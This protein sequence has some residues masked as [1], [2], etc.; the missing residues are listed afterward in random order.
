MD[1]PNKGSHT[2]VFLSVLVLLCAAG[3]FSRGFA[4][5]APGGGTSG[6]YDAPREIAYS[7]S[8]YRDP[9]GKQ[10]LRM[11]GEFEGSYR[12]GMNDILATIWDFSD[13][14]NTFSRIE[15]VRMRS[16]T[17]TIA[18][19]EQRTMVRILGFSY[20]STAVFM[21]ALVRTGP[22]SAVVDFETIEVDD[23]MLSTKGSWTV[24][25]R[26]DASGCSTYVRYTIESYINPEF[27]LQAA[28]MRIFGGEDL[29]KLLRELGEATTKR[30]KK[31]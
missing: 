28:I 6:L 18:V 2:K 8:D 17:G 13:S 15:S 11:S 14:P 31:D 4:E 5:V 10:W 30:T 7:V 12:A 26:S 16:D 29:L 19:F 22:L 1:S 23:T 24:E 9:N 3:S 21:D 25:D 20:F 27:P